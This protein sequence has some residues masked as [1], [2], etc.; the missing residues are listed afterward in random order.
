MTTWRPPFL[1]SK[2]R[3]T[4]CAWMEK[5]ARATSRNELLAHSPSQIG[6]AY[7][8]ARWEH[9]CG[10]V[11]IC[12]CARMHTYTVCPTREPSITYNW[13]S[14]PERSVIHVST[15]YTVTPLVTESPN[16]AYQ[17]CDAFS[18]HLGPACKFTMFSSAH[19]MKQRVKT[20]A[21]STGQM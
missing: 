2:Q 18:A 1:S 12:T 13:E 9:K 16:H 4:E 20:P 17:H 21:A 10:A 5:I 7:R 15:L 11:L 6:V 3:P 8:N 19:S 14:S